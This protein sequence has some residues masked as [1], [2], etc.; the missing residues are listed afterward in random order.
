MIFI[1]KE[2]AAVQTSLDNYIYKSD[3][4]DPVPS[5]NA[6]SEPKIIEQ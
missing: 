4:Q 5:T 1:V 2:K 6:E 3:K